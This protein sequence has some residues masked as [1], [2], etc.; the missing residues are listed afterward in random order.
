MLRFSLGDTFVQYG[1]ALFD[2]EIEI[3]SGWLIRFYGSRDFM[4]VISKSGDAKETFGP[5]FNP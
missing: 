2:D 5:I 1:Y 3:K 4:G